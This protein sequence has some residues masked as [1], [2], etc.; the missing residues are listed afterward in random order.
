MPPDPPSRYIHLRMREH[1]FA[2]YYYPATILFFPSQLKILYALLVWGSIQL[3]NNVWGNSQQFGTND[4]HIAVI[5]VSTARRQ[6]ETSSRISTFVIDVC[7][8]CQF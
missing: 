3:Q 4:I 6:I 8:T 7:H 1:A 5:R 2:C